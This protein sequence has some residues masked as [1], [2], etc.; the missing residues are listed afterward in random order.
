MCTVSGAGDMECL[1]LLAGKEPELV[2]EVE[3]FRLDIVCLTSTH[4]LGSGTI[5]LERGWT[6]H[7]SGV[8][9][10]VRR[11]AGVGLLIAPQLSRHVLEFTPVDERVASLRLQVG[12]RS[13][14]VVAA[15]GPNNSA[16]YPAFLES[17]GG[18][19]DSA[20]TGD[21]IVLLGDFNAHVGNASDTWR[22]VIGRNGPPDLNPSGVLLLDFCASHSLSITNTMFQ[23]KGVH[24]CMWHQDT[25][26]RRSMIDFVVVSSDLRPRVL[27]TRVKRGAELSTD[28]HLVV[29][30]I[31]WQRRKPDRLGRPK[32]IM[33]VCWER[34]AESSVRQA[35]N[36]HLRESFCQLPG[37]TGDIESE[38]TMFSASIVNAAAQSCGRKVSSACRG[39]NP[40]TRWWTPEVRDAVRLKKECYKALL[41]CSTPEAVDRY[42]QAKRTAA[43]AVAEAKTRDWERFGE[44]M[45]EDYR[46][47]S[48]KFWQ[49]VRRLRRGKQCFTNTVYSAGGE[50]LTSTGDVVGRWKEYFEG[51]LNPTA[52]SSDEEAETEDSEYLKSLDVIGM[53]VPLFKKGDRRVCSNYRGITLLSLPGKVYSRV[54]ERRLRPI[55]EPRM[56]EEQCGFRPGR[57]TLDQLYTLH[58]VLEGSWE[59]AQ[60]V[61][62]CFV[63]LEKAFDRVPRGVLWGVLRE[64]GIRGPLLRAVRSLYDRSRS[65]VRIAG[66]K[67]SSCSQDPEGV[68]FGDHRISSLL[69]ADDVVLMAPSSQHLQHAL[70]RFA[71][72]CEAAGMK[73][74]SS[75]SKAMV[76]DRKKVPCPLQV[77]GESLP[78]VE[79]F[80]Y[81]G[82]LFTSEGKMEHEIDRWIGAASAVMQSLYQTVV[83]KKELSQKAKLSIYRSIY[84]PTLTYGHELWVMTERTRSRI[85]AVKMSFLRRVAGRSLRDRV[86]SSATREELGVEPLLHHIERGQLRWLGHLY[87]MPPGRLL[88]RCSGH[89]PLGGG[90]EEDPG[91]AGET[92]SL[93]CPGNASGSSRKSWRRHRSTTSVSSGLSMK[94]DWSKD[95][96]PDFSPEPAPSDSLEKSVGDSRP[97][98]QHT[99]MTNEKQVHSTTQAAEELQKLLQD[100]K[101]SLRSRC[102]SVTEG[103]E[104]AG[105]RTPLNSIYTELYITEGLSEELTAQ[106]EERRLEK[107]SKKTVQETSIRCQD[108]FKALATEEQQGA[109]KQEEQEE[110]KEQRS[111]RAVLTCGVAGVGK[112]FSVLKF[113]LDWAHGSENQELDLVV[114]LSFR[115]LNLARGGC[116]SLMELIQVF[117]PALDKQTL[118][119]HTL[120]VSKLLFIFDGLDESRLSLDFNCQLISEVTQRSEVSVL[121]VNLIKGTLLPTAL[122]WIT[123]RP[124]AANQIPAQCVHR[125]TE[126]R[127]FITERQKEEYFRKRFTDEEQCKTV[128][129]HIRTSRSL[130]IMCQIPVFCWITATVLDHMLRSN[131]SGALP[132]TLS[133]MYAHFLLVQTQRKRKYQPTSQTTQEKKSLSPDLFM[134]GQKQRPEKTLELT[135]TETDVLLKLGRLAFEHLQKGNVMFYQEDLEHVGLDLTEAS[136]YSGLSTEIFKRES[137]IFNKSVYCFVHLS[138][139]EFLA[140][141]YL[142]HCFGSDT[143]VVQRFL[144]L[145]VN[146]YLNASEFLKHCLDKSLES[147]NGH[148]D[149]FVRF[150]HGL[151]LD[152]NQR[153]LGG[154]L[155]PVK[156]SEIPKVIQNLKEMS[157][158]EESPDR[159]INIFHCLMEMKDQSL[160]QQIQDLLKSRGGSQEELSEFQCS[161]LAYML[162]MSEQVLEELDLEKYKTSVGGRQRLIPAVRNCRKARFGQCRLSETHCEVVA[163]ALKSSP[164]HLKLLD[165]SQN[166][167]SDSAVSVLCAGLQSPHCELSTLR[168]VSS[169]TK[170]SIKMQP[171]TVQSEDVWWT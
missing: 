124:A 23:H 169:V 78:Q 55:V 88:V 32:R 85:Q 47:A 134:S 14:S 61:H 34:L 126:V 157:L 156:Q 36:S 9:H 2:R 29:S 97:R 41:A 66:S 165:L 102:E 31:R 89:V 3:R 131:E 113:C 95:G 155:S 158:K 30:W 171:K 57:G 70:G 161:A 37:E 125:V 71:A 149:L 33:R 54:L 48:K 106:H 170:H 121:L 87:R 140:A 111:I 64:Y 167:L 164:S 51:L 75:K 163:S 72:E 50:L 42:L 74:S 13:L 123:S 68:R 35:F 22:G 141:V 49:T 148:L 76:L 153:L 4:S 117:Y 84:V 143:S 101:L 86:R 11:R 110:Q 136:V 96:P 10:G 67:I 62:M 38:W 109:P 90:Q 59:F 80:K 63:D 119:A 127:G 46:S 27:D 18:V 144:G 43:R 52:T 105:S 21:S 115:E 81:L 122:I 168:S 92:M 28:H 19:L 82:V 135:E 16:E 103:T 7:F 137:V 99:D 132:Q 166:D 107:L 93:D 69:F 40:R 150:L 5:T 45:E 94:S 60:P 162:Q 151:S 6:L 58:R 114:P 79:E 26:G 138:V 139:Q 100:H 130:H 142:L 112:T 17:L 128:L 53:M 73:I 77:G 20:P 24:Q 154:L 83:V 147:S 129:S 1:T 15:Y 65:C 160:L 44:A 12:D 118:T 25:L 116:Y 8:A 146:E 91:H 108:I 133:D 98:A 152:S 120:S 39:G 145:N 56:Q 104:G 159:S